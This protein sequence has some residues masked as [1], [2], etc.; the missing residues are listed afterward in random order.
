MSAMPSIVQ[1][2]WG[3]A[4]TAMRKLATLAALFEMKPWRAKM[5]IVSG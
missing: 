1:K 3:A 4:N 2:Y 5:P